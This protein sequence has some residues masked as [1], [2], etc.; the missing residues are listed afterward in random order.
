LDAGADADSIVLKDGD[1]LPYIPGKTLK[2]LFKDALM[3]I[4]DVGRI[5]RSIIEQIFGGVN[6]DNSSFAGKAFFNNAVLPVQEQEEIKSNKLSEYLYRN[7]AST[8]INDRGVA[9]KGSLR[10]IQVTIPVVME[11]SVVLKEQIDGAEQ[12]F[13]QAFKWLRYIGVSRNRGLG[14]CKISKL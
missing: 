3:E 10:T 12:A 13:E 5:D 1:N 2:G 6:K 8:A 4:A 11:G 9:V 7:I 14:R